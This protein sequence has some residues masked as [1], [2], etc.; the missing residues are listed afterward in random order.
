MKI[1]RI[2]ICFLIITPSLAYEPDK[3]RDQPG[4]GIVA[5]IARVGAVEG[6]GPVEDEVSVGIQAPR[7]L[8]VGHEPIPGPEVEQQDLAGPERM[9]RTEVVA[10][11]W[12]HC[13]LVRERAE[14]MIEELAH[15]GVIVANGFSYEVRRMADLLAGCADA[16][17]AWLAGIRNDQPE[18]LDVRFLAALAASLVAEEPAKLTQQGRPHARW[19]EKFAKR[20]PLFLHEHSEPLHSAQQLDFVETVGFRRNLNTISHRFFP[21]LP[22]PDARESRLSPHYS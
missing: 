10:G 19:L 8:A 16:A 18:P 22:S 13:G 21:F 15:L 6:A 7:H 4:Q 9:D 20:A 2:I 14:A 5:A 1:T 11:A 17:A 12:S 3:G